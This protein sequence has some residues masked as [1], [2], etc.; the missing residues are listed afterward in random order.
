M[1]CYG[2]RQNLWL[3]VFVDLTVF[4]LQKYSYHSYWHFDL[5]DQIRVR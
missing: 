5:T 3:Y 2:A 4:N 1:S